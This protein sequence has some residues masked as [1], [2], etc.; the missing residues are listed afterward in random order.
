LFTSGW[1]QLFCCC[2]PDKQSFPASSGSCKGYPAHHLSL[3]PLLILAL[4]LVNSGTVFASPTQLLICRFGAKYGGSDGT[5]CYLRPMVVCALPGAS[6]WAQVAYIPPSI[7]ATQSKCCLSHAM[8]TK[9]NVKASGLVS[10]M[11]SHAMTPQAL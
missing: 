4:F 3:I 10:N 11:A 9:T 6:F 1:L 7:K 8:V 2:H 5:P